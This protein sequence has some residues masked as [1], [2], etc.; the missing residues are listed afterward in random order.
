[1]KNHTALPTIFVAKKRICLREAATIIKAAEEFQ[2]E[3]T[4]ELDKKEEMGT[5]N[6]IMSLLSLEILPEDHCIIR[7]TGKEPEKAISAIIKAL[8]VTEL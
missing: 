6:S 4:I 7:A 1:M 5:S 2:S 3:I 8:E